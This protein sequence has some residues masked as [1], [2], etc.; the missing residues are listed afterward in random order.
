M[1]AEVIDFKPEHSAEPPEST[2]SFCGIPKSKAI[3]AFLVNGLNANICAACVDQI[4]KTLNPEPNEL[5]EP[6]EDGAA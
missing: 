1:T 3:G 6:E 5:I 4:R 2:C